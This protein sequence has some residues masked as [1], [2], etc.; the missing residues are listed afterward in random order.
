MFTK[1]H[2]LGPA[3]G[4]AEQGLGQAKQSLQ[5]GKPSGQVGREVNRR[6]KRHIDGS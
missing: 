4:S 5:A 3:A 1:E 2:I 6:H